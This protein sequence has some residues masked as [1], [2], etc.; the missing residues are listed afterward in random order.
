MTVRDTGDV[1]ILYFQGIFFCQVSLVELFRIA[2]NCLEEILQ[3]LELQPNIQKFQ[4]LTKE[5]LKK[6]PPEEIKIIQTKIAK[7]R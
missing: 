4:S 7:A 6:T 2:Q 1:S 5:N 3:I